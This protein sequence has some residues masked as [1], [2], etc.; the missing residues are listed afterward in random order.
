VL[1]SVAHHTTWYGTWGYH[2]GRGT[3][4]ATK[5]TWTKAAKAVHNA[6]L[7]ALVYDFAGVD[8]GLP[9]IIARY[10]V[11]YVLWSQAVVERMCCVAGAHLVVCLGNHSWVG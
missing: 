8:E 3:Y 4:G 1:H 11:S 10:R 6:L 2:L 5:E 7:D 9:A